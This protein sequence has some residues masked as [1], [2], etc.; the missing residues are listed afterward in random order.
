MDWN[1]VAEQL[2][3]IAESKGINA[4]AYV[5]DDLP[6][7]AF[8]VGEMDIE[9]NQAF[10]K[11]KPDGSRA[12]T[13]QANITCRLLVARSTDRHAIIEMRKWLTGGGDT[14]LLEAFQATNANPQTYEW[15]GIK[16]IAM[17][18]NRLFN[19]G[20]AKFYGTEFEIFVIGAA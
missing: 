14:S 5:P 11:R 1:T 7:K 8:Y 20:E 18:G 6:N 2:E 16:V 10:N 19:V 4:L 9:P 13:D 3:Q 17:R 12:G 15:S